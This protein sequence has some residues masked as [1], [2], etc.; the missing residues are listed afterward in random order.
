M[1]SDQPTPAETPPTRAF[2]RRVVEEA[3]CPYSLD[4]PPARDKINK[5]AGPRIQ[6]KRYLDDE[7]QARELIE[8]TLP[9]SLPW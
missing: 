2:L 1:G 6:A 9:A 8:P 5:Q 3:S 7:S 4:P